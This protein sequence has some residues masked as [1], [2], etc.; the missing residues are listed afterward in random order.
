MQQVRE[1]HRARGV[2]VAGATEGALGLRLLRLLRRL[3]ERLRVTTR[4]KHLASAGEEANAD[5]GRLLDALHAHGEARRQGIVHGVVGRWPVERDDGNCIIRSPLYLVRQLAP[6]VCRGRLGQLWRW[7][8]VIR[9]AILEKIAQPAGQRGG[10]SVSERR[11]EAV[12]VCACAEA[13]C[14]KRRR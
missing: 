2:V 8:C 7:R 1:G 5:V 9:A 12:C 4:A 3:L 10:W 11:A 13:R 14:N 6:A